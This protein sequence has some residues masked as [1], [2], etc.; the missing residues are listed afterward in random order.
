MVRRGL[1]RNLPAP[2]LFGRDFVLGRFVHRGRARDAL[3]RVV[4]VRTR[5]GWASFHR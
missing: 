3:L 5:G 1:V 4:V 2:E